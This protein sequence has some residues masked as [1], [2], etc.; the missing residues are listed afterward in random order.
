MKLFHLT[1]MRI[2]ENH[3]KKEGLKPQPIDPI[4]WD[5]YSCDDIKCRRG[6]FCWPECSDALLSD[7]IFFNKG[8]TGNRDNEFVLLEVQVSEKILLKPQKAS[9]ELGIYHTFTITSEGSHGNTELQLHIKVPLHIVTKRIKPKD[10]V[11]VKEINTFVVG[12]I[13][14]PG[15][16]GG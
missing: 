11:P 7:W 8:K 2:Y 16:V 15:R 5:S 4:W 12:L 13:T 6:I 1:P 3:I 9:D 10:I 14:Q